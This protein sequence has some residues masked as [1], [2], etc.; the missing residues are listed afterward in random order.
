MMPVQRSSSPDLQRRDSGPISGVA[1][2]N[3]RLLQEL[4]ELAGTLP[5]L[6]MA[7]D[8]ADPVSARATAEKVEASLKCALRTLFALEQLNL[9]A[10]DGELEFDLEPPTLDG[11]R[12]AVPALPR[13]ADLCFAGGL[14]L[15]RALQELGRAGGADE[16]LIA[17]ETALRKLW[18]AIR[19]V[20]D[21]AHESGVGVLATGQHLRQSGGFDLASTLLV[22]RLYAVFRRG[23]RRAESEDAQAVLMTLR[24]AAG[25]LA[26]L[27]SS[28]HYRHARVSDRALLRRL[29][30]RVLAWA[31]SDKCTDRGLELLEDVWTSA[32]L[33]RGINRR[34]ELRAH[35]GALI[36]ELCCGSGGDAQAWLARVRPLFGLDDQLDALIDRTECGHTRPLV[37]EVRLRLLQLR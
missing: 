36:E 15:S 21:V 37:E 27:M 1:D 2:D 23:L 5:T 10:S 22:R 18:R 28:P 29:Q 19:A 26:N 14:E 4:Y 30:E 20:L 8:E 24:Y 35:D 25:A 12:L 7:R 11:L 17:T 31:R 6:D 34:Q 16:L 3:C 13:L 32:D 9:D 33:L